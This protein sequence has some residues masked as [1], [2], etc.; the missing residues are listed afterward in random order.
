MARIRR[1]KTI[2]GSE[3]TFGG[4]SGG[5]G[6]VG[7]LVK[8]AK[9][10]MNT[11]SSNHGGFLS[12]GDTVS[13]TLDAGTAIPTKDQYIYFDN[14]FDSSTGTFSYEFMNGDTALPAGMS[15]SQNNDTEG[16][17]LGYAGFT[18]TPSTEGTNSFKIKAF[19]NLGTTS[20]QVEIIYKIKRYAVGTTPV[21]SSTDLLSLIVRNQAGDQVLAAAPTTTYADAT[22]TLSNVSGFATG[23]V[24]TI[25]A[26]TGEVV[27]TGVGDIVQ[28]ASVHAF[29]VTADLG[30]E[31]GTFTQAFSG[32]ISYGDPYGSRYFGPVNAYRSYTGGDYRTNSNASYRDGSYWHNF[33]INQGA[34]NH[35]TNQGRSSTPYTATY[36]GVVSYSDA[37]GVGT[38]Q[39]GTSASMSSNHLTSLVNSAN[40]YQQIYEWV[41]PNGVTQ[42]SVVAVGAGSSGS[43]NWSAHG[44]GGGGLAYCNNVTCTPGEVFVVAI[45]VAR[46]RNPSNGQYHSGDTFLMR[47]SNSEYIV[48]GYG[49]GHYSGRSAPH[50]WIGSSRTP[51]NTTPTNPTTLTHSSNAQFNNQ[52]DA[53][54]ASASTA[55]GS[56]GAFY[57]GWSTGYGH[58]GGAA[59]YRG[60]GMGGSAAGSTTSGGP[61][62]G[63]DYSSTWGGS[64]GGGIGLDGNGRGVSDFGHQYGSADNNS[65]QNSYANIGSHGYRHGGGGGS[66]GTRG[67]WGENPYTGRGHFEGTAYAASGGTHGGGGGGS[68]SST[69]AGG[70]G[71]PGGLRIIWGAVG[72][73]QRAF[74][75]TY[76]TERVEINNQS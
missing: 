17:D 62:N 33:N 22:F 11:N 25:D 74:P 56:R 8:I 24:P 35:I 55:Y 69:N 63:R 42:F 14:A 52:K 6:A 61:R 21:W 68:G 37:A 38:T 48:I 40:G 67:D 53:G 43:Y 27:V 75:N 26:A 29:T 3:Y 10:N 4:G 44:G 34:L 39:T 28:A 7:G 9:G 51:S 47:N 18:G 45:G 23:V 41:V 19:Y 1:P 73:T 66:G 70:R 15:F 16:S 46:N 50:G 30:S 49:G 59:G 60:T 65:N 2:N 32:S 36:N 54:S 76:T 71:G 57:G 58:G 64:G 5:G 13:I 31:I 72:G 12:S 20:E